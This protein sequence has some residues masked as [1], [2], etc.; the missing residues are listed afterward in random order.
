MSYNVVVEHERTVST[1]KLDN[2]DELN[3]IFDKGKYFIL[4]LEEIDET[5]D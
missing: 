4:D 5:I 1:V 2:L 3:Q